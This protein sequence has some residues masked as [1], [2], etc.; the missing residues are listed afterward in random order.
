MEKERKPRRS[1]RQIK[2]L[3]TLRAKKSPE[4]ISEDA[5]KAAKLSGGHFDRQRSIDANK[6]RWA[7]YRAAKAAE[8]QQLK[9]E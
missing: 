5:R 9:G 1:S 6:K 3:R 4:Q 8:A 2:R 7:A